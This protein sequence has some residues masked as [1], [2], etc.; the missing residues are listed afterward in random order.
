MVGMQNKEK[1]L[2]KK[3]ERGMPAPYR[4][5]PAFLLM[6]APWRS[7]LSCYCG[8]FRQPE[9]IGFLPLSTHCPFPA[10]SVTLTEA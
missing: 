6:P 1:M 10:T 7:W 4:K 9:F 3:K 8:S 2:I 5:S